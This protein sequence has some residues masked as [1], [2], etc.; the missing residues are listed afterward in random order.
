SAM[1]RVDYAIFPDDSLP[2]PISNPQPFVDFYIV[3]YC[4]DSTK[5][6]YTLT[7]EVPFNLNKIFRYREAEFIDKWTGSK[8]TANIDFGILPEP[9]PQDT[10]ENDSLTT[11]IIVVY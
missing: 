10:L 1:L 11:S 9:E 5:K 6:E 8:I 7:T 4:A 2:Q 3:Y